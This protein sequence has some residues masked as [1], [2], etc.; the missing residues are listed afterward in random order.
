MISPTA[1][2]RSPTALTLMSGRLFAAGQTSAMSRPKD[3]NGQKEDILLI[4]DDV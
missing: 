4:A 3:D 1:A 2:E